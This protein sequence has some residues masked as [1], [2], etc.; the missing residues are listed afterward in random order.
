M[1]LQTGVSGI[2]S[3]LGIAAGFA[4][5]QLRV[6]CG[7]VIYYGA[8]PSAVINPTPLANDWVSG[9]FERVLPE[10]AESLLPRHFLVV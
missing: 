1:V 8:P 6:G 9:G 5:V 4:G 3:R 10:A 7:G 2:L